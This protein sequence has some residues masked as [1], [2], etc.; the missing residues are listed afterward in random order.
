[1][2][3]IGQFGVVNKAH[4]VRLNTS[5]QT[6]TIVV[7]AKMIKGKYLKL[8]IVNRKQMKNIY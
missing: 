2:G 6:Q 8:N 1:M 4:L 5:G 3:T 7:A